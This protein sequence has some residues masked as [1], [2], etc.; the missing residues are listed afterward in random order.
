MTLQKF[1]E[2]LF[3]FFLNLKK[4]SIS[5]I[6]NQYKLITKYDLINKFFYKNLVELP[7]LKKIIM[8]L[9]CNK[10]LNIK[11]LAIAL[12]SLELISK[13]KSFVTKS[14]KI[15]IIT[16]IRKGYPI[17]CKIILHNIKMNNF[18]FKLL[19]YIFPKIKN[20]YGIKVKT[21]KN[22]ITYKLKTVFVFPELEKQ[23]NIFKNLPFL[24]INFISA[25]KNKKELKFLL[26]SYKLPII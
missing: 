6:K 4:M 22:A 24:S 11:N 16:K 9:D 23:Y 1:Q 14:T 19:F 17:G 26:K 5:I 12:L 13:Q 7:K 20:F 10:N 18:I 15:N 8:S 2:K 3:K 25:I 21:K